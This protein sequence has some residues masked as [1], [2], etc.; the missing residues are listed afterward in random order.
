MPPHT[1]A[2]RDCDLDLI[3]ALLVEVVLNKPV[4][5]L[6][7]F[8]GNREKRTSLAQVGCRC[9]LPG[10]LLATSSLIF[11]Q[12]ARPHTTV[13]GTSR[14]DSPNFHKA[15]EVHALKFGHRN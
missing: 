4:A 8:V 7:R 15:A 2:G 3:K 6:H 14:L 11:T 5:E 13:L 10:D 9:S 1:P 12:K